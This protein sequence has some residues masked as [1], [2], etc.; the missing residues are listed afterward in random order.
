[1][2]CPKCGNQLTWEQRGARRLG[3]CACNPCGPVVDAPVSDDD[4]IPGLGV[5]LRR[6]LER[7]GYPDAAAICAKSDEE[8]LALPGIGKGRVETIRAWC[9]ARTE[10]IEEVLN[11]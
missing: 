4:S 9:T 10:N 8:L 3:S 5:E 2:E 1:M 11:G 6:V 7:L